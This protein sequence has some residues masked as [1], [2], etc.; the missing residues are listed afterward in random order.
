MGHRVLSVPNFFTFT[1]HSQTRS[2]RHG[3]Y[4]SRLEGELALGSVGKG[5]NLIPTFGSPV[6]EVWKVDTGDG[7]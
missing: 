7:L 1:D 6:C 4:R 3:E 5:S 2:L